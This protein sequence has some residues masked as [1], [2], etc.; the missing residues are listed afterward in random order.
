LVFY[1]PARDDKVR[2]LF[3]NQRFGLICRGI[4]EEIAYA[5]RGKE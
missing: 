5:T 4:I 1:Q 3:G 2:E